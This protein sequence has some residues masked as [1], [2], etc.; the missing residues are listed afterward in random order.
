[1]R[2]R[3]G[4]ATWCADSLV[5]S[6][7]EPRRGKRRYIF[8]DGG[9]RDDRQNFAEGSHPFQEGN[10]PKLGTQLKAVSSLHRCWKVFCQLVVHKCHIISRTHRV[11]EE[12]KRKIGQM[13]RG[14]PA[15]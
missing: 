12:T 1:M 3:V 13:K 15:A 9:R 8:E 4:W 6:L 5:T 7:A 2:F 10:S 14:D 11:V